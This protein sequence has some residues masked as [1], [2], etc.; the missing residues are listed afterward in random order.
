MVSI[1]E[2]IGLMRKI[3]A[4]RIDKVDAR[5]AVLMSDFLCSEML[6]D[7][8]GVVCAAFYAVM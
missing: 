5:E 7:C 3:G 4:T 8:D 2:D 6:L 1:R